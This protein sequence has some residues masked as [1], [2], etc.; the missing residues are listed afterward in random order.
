M[1]NKVTGEGS[2]TAA[3]YIYDWHDERKVKLVWEKWHTNDNNNKIWLVCYRNGAGGMVMNTEVVEM[4]TK[5]KLYGLC[6]NLGYFKSG[7][8]RMYVQA[9]KTND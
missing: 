7:G 2:S 3:K 5:R 9:L 8:C 1:I 6:R 4:E